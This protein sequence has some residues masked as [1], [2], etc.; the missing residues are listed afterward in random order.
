MK[1][2]YGV[3]RQMKTMGDIR[4]LLDKDG[5]GGKGSTS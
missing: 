3:D 1:W 2:V 4:F 5:G